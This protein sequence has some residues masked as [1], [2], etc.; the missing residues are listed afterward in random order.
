MYLVSCE[1]SERHTSSLLKA[2]GGWGSGQVV[3]FCSIVPSIGAIFV[4]RLESI[5]QR[6]NLLS[7]LP[8]CMQFIMSTHLSDL[9]GPQDQRCL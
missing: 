6:K 3:F 9:I 5:C 8:L 7:R 2:R 1:G 4:P